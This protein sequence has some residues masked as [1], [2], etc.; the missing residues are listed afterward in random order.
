MCAGTCMPHAY[1]HTCSHTH[2]T[3]IHP[4]MHSYTCAHTHVHVHACAR[5]H[6]RMHMHHANTHTHLLRGPGSSSSIP[7]PVA[8]AALGSTALAADLCPLSK[9]S[10]CVQRAPRVPTAV[11]RSTGMTQDPQDPLLQVFPCPSTA[12]QPCSTLHR[13]GS[14]TQL[15]CS[16]HSPSHADHFTGT[17]STVTFSQDQSS[18]L[19]SWRAPWKSSG[20]PLPLSAVLVPAPC[21]PR[22]P[23]V[24]LCPLESK[25]SRHA[26][27]SSARNEA[28]FACVGQ[29][30]SNWEVEEAALLVIVVG[31]HVSH[32]Y[33]P[34]GLCGG[35]VWG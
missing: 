35:T 34:Q 13:P 33:M 28:S 5:T 25:C 32:Q 24:F 20:V 1:V 23:A 30:A 10:P 9:Q 27:R 4:Y 11:R 16:G 17:A 7:E 22:S 31:Q 3:C 6:T 18:L 21:Q 19:L 26:A 29:R 8:L 14:S 12:T 2:A 15:Q